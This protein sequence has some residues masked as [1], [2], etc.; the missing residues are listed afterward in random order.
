MYFVHFLMIWDIHFNSPS[1]AFSQFQPK[2]TQS[3]AGTTIA[4]H[5]TKTPNKHLLTIKCV[6]LLFPFFFKFFCCCCSCCF[7]DCLPGYN[8]RKS[9]KQTH[10]NGAATKNF[11]MTLLFFVGKIF[12]RC[13]LFAIVVVFCSINIF[14]LE[15]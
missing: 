14:F 6:C 11:W 8:N 5:I 1:C 10:Y 3:V 12:F 15:F 9:T 4:T 2:Y 13:W 7:S